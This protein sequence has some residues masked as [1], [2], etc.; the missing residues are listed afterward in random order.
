MGLGGLTSCEKDIVPE[1]GRLNISVHED[2]ANENI[3][4]SV[5]SLQVFLWFTPELE[6]EHIKLVVELHEGENIKAN[7]NTFVEGNV[8][9]IDVSELS[10]FPQN[11]VSGAIM[12]NMVI[13]INIGATFYE[14]F[15]TEK[16]AIP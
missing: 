6:R 3:L 13:G 16:V 9:D 7:L 14:L 15:V 10:A 8:M 4:L 5:D 2:Y 1:R 12:D 11:G